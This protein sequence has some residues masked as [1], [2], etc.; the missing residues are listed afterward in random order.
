ML[1]AP[2]AQLVVRLNAS[3]L[4]EAGWELHAGGERVAQVLERAGLRVRVPRAL[5]A[6]HLRELPSTWSKRL[7]YG[8]SPEAVLVQAA[9]AAAAAAT[10][11][12]EQVISASAGA[13]AR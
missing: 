11:P 10:P 8:R 9:A 6:Q 3:A 12:V 2:G 7:A 4:A 13:P 5:S 1:M